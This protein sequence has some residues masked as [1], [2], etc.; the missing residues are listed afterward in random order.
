MNELLLGI[1]VGTSATKAVLVDRAGR[2]VAR[3][4]GSYEVLSPAPGWTEQ[5]PQD[6]WRGVVTAVR[7]ALGSLPGSAGRVEAVGLSGQM[8]GA[9]VV[10]GAG[11][12]A[13]G[14]GAVRALRPAILW[15]DQRTAAECAWIEEAVGGRAEL[16]RLVGNRA[17]TGFTLPKLVWLARHEP[18]VWAKAA[19]VLLPKDFVRLL[20]TGEAATDA[21]DASGTL[22]FDVARGVWS[23][24][25]CRAVGLDA[26][27]LPRV[28]GSGD[29]AGSLTAWAAGE[30]GLR[31]GVPVIAG[32]GDNQTAAV[33]AGVTEPGEL[34]L[35]LGTS[36][37]VLAPSAS[38]RV[39]LAG[40]HSGRVQANRDGTGGAGAAGGWCN[41]GVMLSAAGS[42]SWASRVLGASVEELL[43]EAEGVEPGSGGVLFAPYLSGERCPHAS[44][45][46]RGA[47]AG[48][49]ASHGRGHLARAVLEGVAMGLAQIVGLMRSMGVSAERARVTG[50]GARSGLWRQIIAD[51]TGLPLSVP[52][53]E[54]GSALGAALMAGAGAGAWG[55][56]REA[57]RLVGA[58][59]ATTPS[60]EGGG[61]L[62]RARVAF[63]TLFHA[64]D[65][66]NRTLAGLDAPSESARP[67]T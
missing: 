44:P 17:L 4:A 50:G 26:R 15:N 52:E 57:A 40:A 48:M 3:G 8:H 67:E 32:S 21:G 35:I 65:G 51:A 5:D 43:R 28:V 49:L 22:V 25:V 63:D 20:M 39:D 56:V 12:A 66:T 42:L 64:L 13:A 36:G 34:L 61:A 6:W 19:C 9:V 53:S 7:G 24:A 60:A 14:R 31:A 2:V 54:E 62:S 41:T 47:W 59:P 29:A 23:E 33:G 1:D 55:S 45:H 10:D 16:V 37:V 46:A 11:L 18:E 38:P 30:L 58:G 27:L